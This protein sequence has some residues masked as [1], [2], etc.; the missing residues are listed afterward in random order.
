MKNI[1][2]VT[3]AFML[4]DPQTKDYIEERPH[5]VTWT[6]FLEAR[7]GKGQIKI[8]AANL[9]DEASDIEFQRYL[10]EAEDVDLAVASYV[11]SFEET[12]EEAKPKPRSRSKKA[13]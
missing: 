12:E 5:V 13:E 11:S 1:V 9:P 2:K 6:Q 10:D 3:G 8:L 4:I 7:T